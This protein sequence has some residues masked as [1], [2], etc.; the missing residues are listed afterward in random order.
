MSFFQYATPVDGAQHRAS[1]KRTLARSARS[2]TLTVLFSWVT[3]R[4][5]RR[6]GEVENGLHSVSRD[7][8]D[9]QSGTR[10]IPAAADGCQRRSSAQPRLRSSSLRRAQP[11]SD[12]RTDEELMAAY[13]RGER[14]AFRELFARYAP[15][16]G[17]MM[18]KSLFRVRGRGRPRAADF[19][20]PSPGSPR[21]R[22]EP[23]G[24]AVAVHDR[25]ERQD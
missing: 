2:A 25:N 18:R 13:I 5:A 23:T 3:I 15:T 19:P 11:G 8:H 24:A 7:N 9:H 17:R 6:R 12:L 1:T 4:I 14:S 22:C 21:L 20:P 16:L 10:R